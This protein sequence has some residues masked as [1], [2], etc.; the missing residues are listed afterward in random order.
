MSIKRES[1]TSWE[2]VTSCGEHNSYDDITATKDGLEI[3]YFG[4]IPWAELDEA[5]AIATKQSLL[6]V[7]NEQLAAAIKAGA[8]LGAELTGLCTVRDA[9]ALMFE[10]KSFGTGFGTSSR[11]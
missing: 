11:W 10:Q 4:D 8:E 1:E 2:L 5:R 9:V 6:A 7:L 3:G